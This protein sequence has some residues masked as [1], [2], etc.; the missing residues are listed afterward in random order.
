VTGQGSG[1][2]VAARAP[3]ADRIV[4]AGRCDGVPVGGECDGPDP[5]VSSIGLSDEPSIGRIPGP[6]DMVHPGRY[7]R[8]TVWRKRD[9]SDGWAMASERVKQFSSGGTPQLHEAAVAPG[10]KQAAVRRKFKGLNMADACVQSATG[11]GS[12]AGTAVD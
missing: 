10:R 3:Q 8:A 12:V 1:Y 11:I 2:A 7:E 9:R 6:Y 5:A 4:V